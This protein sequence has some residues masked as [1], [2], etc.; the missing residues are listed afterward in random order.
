MTGCQSERL[1]EGDEPWWALITS[2]LKR[3]L[4][5]WKVVLV[6]VL[7]KPTQE[8]GDFNGKP[9]GTWE[10]ISEGYSTFPVRKVLKEMVPLKQI[11]SQLSPFPRKASLALL[12]ILS[13]LLFLNCVATFTKAC[14]W[15]TVPWARIVSKLLVV[16]CF[17]AS[18]GDGMWRSMF[19]DQCEAHLAPWYATL[20]GVAGKLFVEWGGTSASYKL[21]KVE[22]QRYIWANETK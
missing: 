18:F 15:P 20:I 3:N 14:S 17:V 21:P 6:A 1:F 12:R 8:A 2:G 13:V 22:Q 19:A 10:K 11:M 16:Q 4:E 9:L 5:Y 7:Q